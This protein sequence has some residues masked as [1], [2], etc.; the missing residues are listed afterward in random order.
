LT[1]GVI[2]ELWC[3]QAIK[4]LLRSQSL[5]WNFVGN[6]AGRLWLGVLNLITVPVYVHLL[7]TEAFGIVAM[8]GTLHAVLAI[9][10]LGLAGTANREVAIARGIGNRSHLADTIRTFECI[11]W[12][13][14]LMIGLGFAGLSNWLANSWVPKKTL[15]STEIQTAIILGGLALAARWPGT[16]S[17]RCGCRGTGANFSRQW[18]I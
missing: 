18:L 6:V 1:F 14:A 9:L 5:R 17:S 2:Q 3:V 8:V 16:R 4:G 12:M 15:S 11:Y 10:D 13:V 7:G